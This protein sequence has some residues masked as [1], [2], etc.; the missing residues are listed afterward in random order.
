M[1][2]RQSFH[3]FSFLPKIRL[4]HGGDIGKGKRKIT[5]PFDPKRALHIVL[6]SSRA[7]GPWS[8]LHPR[9]K[10]RVSLLVQATAKRFDVTIYRY[11]NVGNHF[12]FL[13][14]AKSRRR[15][16]AFLRTLT[17][18][19]ACVV[20][21]AK[22]ASAMVGRF[23]DK[24]AYSRIVSWGRE[25]EILKQYLLKN[26]FEALGVDRKTA[27]LL[28]AMQRSLRDAGLAPPD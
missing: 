21:G 16:Q 27:Q 4:H 13:L 15:L 12:H 8:F 26:L 9:H 24:L 19:I 22:K 2:R 20:S 6:R 5:R 10:N 3:Q 1:A 14:R 11:A 28:V 7:R 25:Y 18:R 23:W 17:G